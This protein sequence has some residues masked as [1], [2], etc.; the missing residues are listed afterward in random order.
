MSGFNWGAGHARKHRQE[1][2]I[3]E[4]AGGLCQAFK[5]R[6]AALW[7]LEPST[8]IRPM[9]ARPGIKAGPIEW[10]VNS[11]TQTVQETATHIGSDLLT[12]RQAARP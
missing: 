8:S 7:A 9:K 1:R 2:A 12:R 10:K 3:H 4:Q 6:Q 11:H 5:K